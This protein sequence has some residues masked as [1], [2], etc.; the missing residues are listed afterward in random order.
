M[1]PPVLV[2]V[3]GPP[4]TGKTYCS[5]LL[6]QRYA[7][8]CFGKDAFKDAMLAR[9]GTAVDWPTSRAFSAAS[10]DALNTIARELLPQRVSHAIEANFRPEAQTQVLREF[11][12]AFECQIVQ[13]QLACQGDVLLQRFC[14][15]ARAG[16]SHLG[17][18]G[19]RFLEHLRPT[20][21]QGY[22]EAFAVESAC[23]TI[24]TTDLSRVDCAPLFALL[25]CKLEP[26]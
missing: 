8:P 12:Q 26:H 13:V 1:A 5:R 16:E 6:A 14:D 19:L 15:R 7:L 21:E 18:Q 3:A 17:H 4:A 24:D 22:L 20:L 2:V 9:A 23:V 11:K 25:D 10:I